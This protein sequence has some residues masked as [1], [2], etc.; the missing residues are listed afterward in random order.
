MSWAQSG[1]YRLYY[2]VRGEGEPLALVP[3]LGLSTLAWAQMVPRLEDAYRLV[4]VDPRGA[5]QS[6]K[7]DMS[8]TGELFAEDLAA[9]L[10]DVG[11]DRAHIVGLSMGGMIAQE[12]SIRF[13]DR[14]G[15]LILLSTY[16]ATDDWSRRLFEVRR[17]MIERL[18]LIEHFK[19][20]IMFVFSPAAFRNIREQVRAIESALI[21]NPPDQ[22]AYLRQVQY[23]LE[24]DTTDRLA[25]ITAPTLVVTGSHDIL[26]SPLQG[27]ELAGGIPGAEY[28]EF[29]GASHGLWLEE[30]EAFAVLVKEFLA[31]HPLG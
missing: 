8:Y 27:R 21:D 4:V 3:G 23:C 25:R 31:G 10:D 9:V 7:P 19:L 20:S 16:M 13:P 24:H 5:G 22:R 6:D 18:G 17:T 14:V 30:G 12:F 1:P 29:P 2:E 11:V 28:R 26:T 15:S